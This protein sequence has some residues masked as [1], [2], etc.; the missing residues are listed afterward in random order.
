[1]SLLFIQYSFFHCQNCLTQKQLQRKVLPFPTRIVISEKYNQKNKQQFL[2]ATTVSFS[3]LL[4][5]TFWIYKFTQSVAR[6]PPFAL[7][8]MESCVFVHLSFHT[9][10]FSYV[11]QQKRSGIKKLKLC[12]DDGRCGVVCIHSLNRTNYL[13]T[14]CFVHDF[15]IS[16]ILY[17]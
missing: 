5:I 10:A 14:N 17:E 4:F 6:Q 2:Y 8:G 16:F 11:C 13:D 12:K 7:R 3:P 9:F 1:M 15:K